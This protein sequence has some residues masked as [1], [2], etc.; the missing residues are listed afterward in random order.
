MPKQSI[1]FSKTIIY[2]IEKDDDFYVGSSTDFPSRKHKH[3]Y[4][5]NTITDNSYNLKLYETIR[6][7]GGWDTW[8]MTPLEEY[9]DCKSKIQARIRE[10]EWRVKLNADLNM[11]KAY[12]LKRVY[13]VEYHQK[14]RQEHADKIKTV[15]TQKFDCKCGGKYTYHGKSQHEKTKKHQKYLEKE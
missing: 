2:K 15:M 10:E 12:T 8:K 5:C 6:E 9:V 4:R 3:K 7:K 11:R 13:D 14:Y 1:D